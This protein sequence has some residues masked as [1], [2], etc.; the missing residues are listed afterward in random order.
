MQEILQNSWP[1]LFQ[2]EHGLDDGVSFDTLDYQLISNQ[3]LL[4][5]LNYS[6]MPVAQ[7]LLCWNGPV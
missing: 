3:E 4:K 7:T 5:A 1:L 2:C 6:S